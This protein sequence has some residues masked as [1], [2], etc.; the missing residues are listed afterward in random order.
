MKVLVNLDRNLL[1]LR[2]EPLE[3]KLSDVLADILVTAST[4][5]PAKTVA[6]AMDFVNKGEAEVELSDIEFIKGV[7]LQN[8]QVIDLAKVQIIEALE[9]AVKE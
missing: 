9:D 6:L 5:R 3:G 1:T 8:N 4:S 7:V 2:G